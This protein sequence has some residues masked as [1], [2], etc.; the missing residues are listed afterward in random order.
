MNREIGS[1]F[2]LYDLPTE[3]VK[4]TPDWISSWGN[5]VLTSSGRGAISLILKHVEDN[6]I[7]KT[8]L[9]P[10][11][12]CES[13]IMPFIKEGYTCYFYDVDI[14]LKPNIE[15][16]NILLEKQIG[17]F[18]HMGYFGFPTNDNL[19][20]C[21]SQLKKKGT[22]IVEDLTHTLFSKY[23]RYPLNDYYIASLR[24]WT[25]LPSGGFVASKNYNIQE[26]LC[27]QTNFSNIREKALLLK[28]KYMKSKNQELK[29]RYLDMFKEAENILDNDL[30]PYSID[31]LSNSILNE[32]DVDE[33][34][35]KRTENFIFLLK[36]LGDIKGIEPVFNKIPDSVCPLFFP[37]YIH[38]GREKIRKLLI[39]ENIYCPIHWPIPKQ[40]DILNY[41]LSQ[42][43][44]RSIL[45]IPCDQRYGADD[46]GRI[47][48]VIHN[49]YL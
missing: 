45:S 13:V 10:V 6:V 40:V 33:L 22:I 1:E 7:S 48:N 4:G 19:Y 21:I 49:Y 46:M 9:L 43:I 2:W 3:Y 5:T 11:Y 25:G 24:K 20:D 26:R 42:K 15:S 23:E 36:A 44:Y 18:L 47:A 30:K 16:I 28:G 38:K 27:V 17:V 31:K 39:D 35:K 8:A 14:N 12:T 41:P 29:Q 34:I 32:L 37:I